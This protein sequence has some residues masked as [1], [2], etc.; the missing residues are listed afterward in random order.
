MIMLP[1]GTSFYMRTCDSMTQHNQNP[2]LFVGLG[3]YRQHRHIFTCWLSVGSC[4]IYVLCDCLRIVVSNAC[5]AVCLFSLP[6]SSVP[7]VASFSGLSIFDCPF[8][9]SLLTFIYLKHYSRGQTIV[10]FFTSFISGKNAHIL[11]VHLILWV[12]QNIQRLLV[13]NGLVTQ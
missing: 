10:H 4:L 8:S 12:L 2:A 7:Y 11:Q 5:C 3:Q 13:V 1:S 6:S 9:Y